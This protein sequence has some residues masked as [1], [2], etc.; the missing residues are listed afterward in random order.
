MR[1]YCALFVGVIFVLSCSKD[2]NFDSEKNNFSE[3]QI[4]DFSSLEE[5]EEKVNEISLSKEK[6]ESN[7]IE[8]PIFEKKSK[9]IITEANNI[10]FF[11][12][13]A[14]VEY[15]HRKKLKI[16][17]EL[18]KELNFTSLQST[19][20]EINSLRLLNPVKAEKLYNEIS[21]LLIKSKFGVISKYQDDISGVLNING[22]VKINGE[23]LDLDSNYKEVIK[24]SVA[25][26]NSNTSVRNDSGTLF[27][28]NLILV[29]WE[30]GRKRNKS[31]FWW[32]YDYY[33]KHYG[34]VK[35]GFVDV[36]GGTYIPYPIHINSH[37]T[38]S[39]SFKKPGLGSVITVNPL[40]KGMT[41]SS[42][43]RNSRSS[44]SYK[45]N[46][47]RISSATY[48]INIEG[49]DFSFEGDSFIKNYENYNPN[50]P[51]LFD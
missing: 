2:D 12:I 23:L 22:E 46:K 13:K 49:D 16:I 15:Y 48:T 3:V 24:N 20:D 45:L 36:F 33:F 25:K 6:R 50:E 34:F 26:N 30:A 44:G 40:E 9:E 31:N 29:S 32:R 19:V 8:K 4:L 5:L 43:S 14:D 35:M 1:K 41:N 38:S 17:Y 47:I 18:R 39:C 37:N 27:I 7:I 21:D 11:D 28:N 51:P 10:T 42:T